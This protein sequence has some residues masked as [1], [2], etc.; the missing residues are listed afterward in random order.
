MLRLGAIWGQVQGHLKLTQSNDEGNGQ[1]EPLKD[2]RFRI[3]LDFSPYLE[4][5][6]GLTKGLTKHYLPATPFPVKRRRGHEQQVALKACKRG[7]EL[8]TA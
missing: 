3:R 2:L 6:K 1:G 8:R 4:L 7:R 5:T